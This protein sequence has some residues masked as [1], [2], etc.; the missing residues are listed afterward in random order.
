MPDVRSALIL[1]GGESSPELFAATNCRDRALIPIADAPM[2][3]HVIQALRAVSTIEHIA[4]VGSE[5]VLAAVKAEDIIA[6]AAHAR[7]VENMAAGVEML[8]NKGVLSEQLLACSCDIPL[9]SAATFEELLN[10]ARDL[11][12]AYPIVT[13]TVC[14]SRFPG[15]TRTY[16]KLKDG[17][18]TGGN[19]FVL[20]SRILDEIVTLTGAAYNARKNP[21]GLAKMLGATLMWKFA[22]KKLTIGDVEQR[23]SAVL[24][25][26]AGAV[27]M[28][29]ATIAFDVDKISDLKQVRELL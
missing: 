15:G 24:K 26:R 10:G 9:A 27:E 18:F 11:E 3:A 12:L 22:T 13:R 7:L 14:E 5:A 25:C 29:D 21:A 20:P 2:I 17:E 19:A 1:A 4:V 28:K 6:V 8:R 16:A 23:A